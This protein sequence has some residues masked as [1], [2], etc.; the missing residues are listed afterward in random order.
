MI[1]VFVM[2]MRRI[3]ADICEVP[4]TAG[5]SGLV[6]PVGGRGC[7][8][9]CQIEM[10]SQLEDHIFECRVYDCVGWWNFDADYSYASKNLK[11]TIIFYG[12]QLTDW[13]FSDRLKRQMYYLTVF[14]ATT[15]RL[16]SYHDQNTWSPI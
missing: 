12:L 1:A 11:L 10:I 14:D 9:A 4:V 7:K 16:G 6:D 2:A 15:G 5:P 8:E 13:P 3:T